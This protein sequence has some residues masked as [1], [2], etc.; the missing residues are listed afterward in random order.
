ME[1]GVS[2]VDP[3]LSAGRLTEIAARAEQ[4]GYSAAWTNES[5]AREAF[6]TLAAWAAATSRIPSGHRS[7]AGLRPLACGCR[8]GAPPLFRP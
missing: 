7:P 4:L 3:G 2:L 6:S 8:D 5:T 1:L